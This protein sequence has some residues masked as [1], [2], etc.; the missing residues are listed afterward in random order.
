MLVSGGNTLNSEDRWK[1]AV[2]NMILSQ[3]HINLFLLT[4]FGEKVVKQYYDFSFRLFF[5]RFHRK[6]GKKSFT[7]FIDYIS[8]LGEFL[9]QAHMIINMD[10][11]NRKASFLVVDCLPLDIMEDDRNFYLSGNFPCDIWCNNFFFKF[12]K[13]AGYK[14]ELKDHEEGCLFE[15]SPDDETKES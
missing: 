5:Q 12:C 6:H 14:C 3:S 15:I 8:Y 2:R 13:F 9:G 7:E 11:E 4:R 1:A 10:E